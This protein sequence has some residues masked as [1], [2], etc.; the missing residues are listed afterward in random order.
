MESGI[1]FNI[2][3]FSIH[4]GPGIRTNVFL[5]GCPLRCLWCHNP[6]GLEAEAEVE[7]EGNKCIGCGACGICEQHSHLF[8]QER[9]HIYDRENCIR[10]G[11]CVEVCPA[12]ALKMAG[13]RQTVDE[14]LDKV[15]ADKP[16]YDKSGGGM[17]LSGGEP[18]YQPAFALALLREAKS[19]GLHTAIET[20]GFASEAVFTSIL[21]YT[22]LVLLDYKVTGEDEH[23]K[24]TGVPQAPILA[25][26]ARADAA[27][28]DIVLRCP[29]IP[30]INMH[31]AHYKAIAATADR[32]SHIL[33][34]D[35]EPYHTLGTGKLGRL[36]KK[37]GF[38]T[39]MPE[40][41]EMEQIRQTIQA[42]CTKK[43]CIS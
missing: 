6:E 9:G 25:N 37:D 4:D 12:A 3:K 21:P 38:V 24:Y 30:G 43:V 11:K 13:T 5:K 7:L 42:M 8:S 29:L 18:L 2:Q 20:S 36:G 14:V 1:V 32:Y 27:G 35:L 19:R 39:T 33:R 41:D 10:C 17:T 34:V 23:K 28:V 22:D 31:E 16:F 40:K 26:V 15:M